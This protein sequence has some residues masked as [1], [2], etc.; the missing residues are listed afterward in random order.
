MLSLEKTWCW[1]GL[2]AGGEGDDRGWDG[3][4]V[5]PTQWTRVWVN[6]G[7]WWW[8]GR[9]GQ[10][11]AVIHGVAKSRTWLSDWTELRMLSIRLFIPLS[12]S[13]FGYSFIY[14]FI[15][16][17]LHICL[18]SFCFLYGFFFFVWYFLLSMYIVVF[19]PL[20]FFL[21]FPRLDNQINNLVNVF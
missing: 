20:I 9:P 17:S 11:S 18:S 8:T 10:G 21:I 12:K 3:W 19:I 14:L 6:S 15:Y 7:S 2:G 4:M 1:A 5:S 13:Q 16:L